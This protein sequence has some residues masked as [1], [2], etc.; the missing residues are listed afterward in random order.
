MLT[1]LIWVV[2]GWGAVT[3]TAKVKAGSTVAVFGLG[4]IGLAVVEVCTIQPL[5]HP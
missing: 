5:I 2:V 4:V 3:K 1:A